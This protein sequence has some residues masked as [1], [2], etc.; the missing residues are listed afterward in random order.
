MPAHVPAATQLTPCSK[1]LGFPFIIIVAGS[2]LGNYPVLV[3][4]LN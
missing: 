4:K 3:K 2:R 1:G